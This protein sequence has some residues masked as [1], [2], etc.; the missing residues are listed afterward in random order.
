MQKYHF[1]LLLISV[2]H[3]VCGRLTFVVD[4]QGITMWVLFAAALLPGKKNLSQ[5]S[6]AVAPS[7]Y[8]P[9]DDGAAPPHKGA[10]GCALRMRSVLEVVAAVQLA[11]VTGATIWV[12]IMNH[13]ADG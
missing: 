4:T 1:R 8:V 2:F 12:A 9:I 6:A 13:Q 10:D 11:L 5:G 7:G 3:T